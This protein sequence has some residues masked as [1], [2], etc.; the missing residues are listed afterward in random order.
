MIHYTYGYFLANNSHL[1]SL[2]AGR[3]RRS[4]V[5]NV[6]AGTKNS[7][8]TSL[9]NAV[10]NVYKY[11]L[12][13]QKWRARFREDIWMKFGLNEEEMGKKLAKQNMAWSKKFKIKMAS[14]S[15]PTID[16]TKILLVKLD[17]NSMVILLHM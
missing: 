10:R 14:S 5:Q 15:C 12:I 3:R 8:T 7:N 17:I 1:T 9:E 6:C 11:Q 16:A 2:A 4:F 13:P